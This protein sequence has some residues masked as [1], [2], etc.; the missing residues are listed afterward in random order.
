MER[1]RLEKALATITIDFDDSHE[2][3]CALMHPQFKASGLK[4]T[5]K[6]ATSFTDKVDHLTWD[7]IAALEH[8]G[9]RE[10]NLVH[11]QGHFV[12]DFYVE[13]LVFS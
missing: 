9:W 2:S 4:G 7:A 11:R 12:S 6:I 1:E 13:V 10:L 3:D 8:L 5:R